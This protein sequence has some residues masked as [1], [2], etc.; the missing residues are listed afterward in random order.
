MTTYELNLPGYILQRKLQ[1]HELLNAIAPYTMN[2]IRVVTFLGLSNTVHIHFAVLRL[3]RRGNAVD[4]WDQGGISVGVDLR[5]GTLRRGIIKPKFG[6]HWVDTHPDSG[7]S[8][9]GLRLPD[10]DQVLDTC[11]RAAEATPSLRSVGWDIAL[12]PD[13]PVLIEG[14]PDWD[15][16]MV[17]V[18]TGGLLQPDV[19]EQLAPFGLE[20]ARDTLPPISAH[21]WSVWYADKQRGRRFL[22]NTLPRRLIRL[23]LNPRQIYRK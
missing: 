8:F 19:R 10:W 2:T 12:T 20:F 22:Q 11:R 9:M 13:G 18:H 14:N 7:V 5:T 1:Q 3:G 16:P 21:R 23:F 17:Q 4:N 6:G 15:L